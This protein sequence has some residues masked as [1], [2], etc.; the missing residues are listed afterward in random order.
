MYFEL[1][2]SINIRRHVLI[3]T[4][5][6]AATGVIRA[7]SSSDAVVLTPEGEMGVNFFVQNGCS[8]YYAIYGNSGDTADGKPPTV[9]IR[10][11]YSGEPY[12]SMDTLWGNQSIQA[13]L[14]KSE[15]I[16]G[17]TEDTS[18][19]YVATDNN[20]YRY[21]MSL[22]WYGSCANTFFQ[23][24][25]S[26]SEEKVVKMA[27]RDNWFSP[28]LLT[29]MN[30]SDTSAFNFR[31]RNSYDLSLLYGLK[32]DMIPIDIYHSYN[33]T[34]V[35]GSQGDSVARLM[36]IDLDSQ[37]VVLDIMMGPMTRNPISMSMMGNTISLLS[38]PGDSISVITTFS[39]TDSVEQSAIFNLDSNCSSYT[40]SAGG[41]PLYCQFASDPTGNNLHRKI[42]QVDPAVLSVSNVY[43]INLKLNSMHIPRFGGFSS[44]EFYLIVNDSL[45]YSTSYV[46][47]TWG[48]VLVDSAPIAYNTRFVNHQITC[49]FALEENLNKYVKFRAYPNPT[50]DH[51]KL[52]VSGVPCN[53]E[54]EVSILDLNG[55]VKHSEMVKSKTSTAFDFKDYSPGI[56]FIQMNIKGELFSQKV[57]KQ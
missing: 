41:A 9:G 19:F 7:Q 14:S 32:L 16:G 57:I 34:F 39:L 50:T 37:S 43:S 54:Y 20:L 55:S 44:S 25:D 6:I 23:K 28:E 8:N 49:A 48:E 38:F 46:F 51:V 3:A 36:K 15:E 26:V 42:T 30:P 56:Y 40:W 53:G 35:I 22:L 52:V 10:C 27:I 24:V 29:I 47:D 2:S 1:V 11:M 5:L 12:Y 18:L 33:G 31:S 4:L 13:V 17:T 21:E 45:D